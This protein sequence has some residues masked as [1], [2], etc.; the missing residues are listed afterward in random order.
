MIY[1]TQKGGYYMNEL[2]LFFNR[3]I[4]KTNRDSSTRYVDH[5]HF[6]LT[7]AVSN[8]LLDLV[9]E[10]KKKATAASYEM[11]KLG[12]ETMPKVGDLNII[13]DFH[14]HPRCVV[15]TKQ[16]TILP[17]KS[18]TFDI[19]KRKGEDENLASWQTGHRRFFMEESKDLGYTFSEDML[20]VFE[21]F[22]VLYIE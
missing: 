8:E 18:F 21:D 14:G 9:I 10:G 5:Y 20:V 13:T 4:E 15:L 16:I 1:S 7:E 12:V 22:E 17:F 6:E 2:E 11:Y 3:F 19:V